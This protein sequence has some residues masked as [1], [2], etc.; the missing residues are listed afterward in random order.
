MPNTIEDLTPQDDEL[1]AELAEW[2]EVT[3]SRPYLTKKPE[4]WLV[5]SHVGFVDLQSAEV[6]GGL[7]KI[8][9]KGKIRA[10]KQAHAA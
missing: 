3:D 10:T 9:R 1:L 4:C 5:L 7:V 8:T 2:D 6:D